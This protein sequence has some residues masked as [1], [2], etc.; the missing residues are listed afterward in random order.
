MEASLDTFARRLIYLPSLGDSSSTRT[1]AL[2]DGQGQ[3]HVASLHHRG[4]EGVGRRNVFSQTL[5]QLCKH[6]LDAVSRSLVESE[7]RGRA[8]ASACGYENFLRTI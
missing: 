1:S 2:I 8:A 4:A 6:V 3:A 7:G 5:D